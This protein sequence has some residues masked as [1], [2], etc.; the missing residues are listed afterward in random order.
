MYRLNDVVL[1]LRPLMDRMLS[2]PE[3]LLRRLARYPE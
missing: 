1:S 2:R 3:W